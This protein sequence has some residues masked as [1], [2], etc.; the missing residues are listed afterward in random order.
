MTNLIRRSALI[1]CILAVTTQASAEVVLVSQSRSVHGFAHAWG[2]FL[3]DL[4]DTD[5]RSTLDPGLFEE[6]I[7]I[8][9]DA[10]Y[11]GAGCS[12]TQDSD[13]QASH[14]L[15]RG[16]ADADAHGGA[17]QT[18]SGDSISGSDF[19]VRFEVVTPMLFSLTGSLT[20]SS[21]DLDWNG[22][23]YL[24]FDSRNAGEIAVSESGLL[25]PGVYTLTVI[26]SA[27]AY[28]E[29]YSYDI[30]SS[31]F[32]IIFAFGGVVAVDE[33]SWGAVKALYDN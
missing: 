23:P 29:G 17:E 22:V 16:S 33:T 28:A 26:A 24:A 4:S 18:G 30:S 32:E 25:E 2:F 20:S 6:G 9:A 19:D 5:S 21:L 1:I 11:T 14:F 7:S 12:A 31:S 10:S 13:I 3:E 15:I 27:S 8:R